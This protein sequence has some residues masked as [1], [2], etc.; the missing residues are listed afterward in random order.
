MK[1]TVHYSILMV[2]ILGMLLSNIT[3]AQAAAI[4][5]KYIAIHSLQASLSISEQ[6]QATCQGQLI[7]VNGYTTYLK[8]ELK[9]DGITIMTWSGSKS[10]SFAI[11]RSHYVTSGHTYS[12]TATATVYDSN[13]RIVETQSRLSLEKFY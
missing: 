9:R 6:G 11:S 4:Q 2:L 10:N 12:V 13:N 8:V 3:V 1:K 7:V 5:P